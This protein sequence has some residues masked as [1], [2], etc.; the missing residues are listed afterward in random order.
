MF[1]K[2][3]TKLQDLLAFLILFLFIAIILTGI[4]SYKLFSNIMVI[5]IAKSRV[6]LLGRLSVNMST[7]KE[8]MSTISSLYYYND[9]IN[10]LLR[11]DSIIKN[12]IKK[13]IDGFNNLNLQYAT[14]LNKKGVNIDYVVAMNNGFSY[15][16]NK[17]DSPIFIDLYKKK[18]W[19]RDILKNKEGM[20]WVSTYDNVI[21]KKVDYV[22]SLARNIKDNNNNIVGLFLVNIPEEVI[23]GV[24][25][26]LINENSIYVIDLS[27][28]IV[29]HHDKRMLGFNFYNMER[30]NTMF[31]D[32]G[33]NMIE[34]SGEKY[35][36]SKY[37]N[38]DF[39]WIIIEEIPLKSILT[40]LINVR[41]IFFI[42]LAGILLLAILFSLII[43]RRTIKP[44]NTLC[45]RLEQVGRGKNKITFDINGWN[46]INRISEECNSMIYR[47]NN[48]INSIRKTERK[49]RKAELDFLQMQINPHFIYNTLFSIKCLVSMSK[50]KQAEKMMGSFIMFLKRVLTSSS[51]M[52]T[53]EKEI[54]ILKEYVYLQKYRFGDKF[55]IHYLCDSNLMNCKIPRLLL[56]PLVENAILHGIAPKNI[57]GTIVIEIKKKGDDISINIIDDGVGMNVD[58]YSE[59]TIKS[60]I[61]TSIGIDNV[62]DRIRFNFG[63]EYSLKLESDFGKG[64]KVKLLLPIKL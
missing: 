27:G 49:K 47:I 43:V 37:Y 17:H 22:F 21:T 48:L 45:N 16:T 54:E 9:P 23:S 1:R 36:F 40:P 5:Q 13:A 24:Y 33:F 60:D 58:E 50:N 10:G 6:D 30:F 57:K 20:T 38:E 42:I 2:K 62:L 59:R 31:D 28:R 8:S 14:A 56:Q 19:Y 12:D 61:S 29:S 7:I 4:I 64:T 63:E 25:E 11:E 32:Y 53:I 52:I 35:L 34:K 51:E 44:L 26:S 3:Q 18:L 46:E 55:D 15:T 39:N 41:K